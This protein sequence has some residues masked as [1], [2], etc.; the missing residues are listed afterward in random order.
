ME[1]RKIQPLD[2]VRVKKG[3]ERNNTY[4]TFSLEK[5][6]IVSEKKE[7]IDPGERN[8]GI[9]CEIDTSGH[10]SV[11]WIG[12]SNLYNA[13]WN[14]ECLEIVDSLPNLLARKIAHPFGNGRGMVDSFFSVKEHG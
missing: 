8:V 5:G 10:A 12:K 14:P 2:F 4:L 11:E 9:V 13:W 3:L 7:P 6:A 1:E